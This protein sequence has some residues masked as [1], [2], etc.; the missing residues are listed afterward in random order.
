MNGNIKTGISEID[1]FQVQLIKGELILITGIDEISNSSFAYRLHKSIRNENHVMYF[2]LEKPYIEAITIE[3]SVEEIEAAFD[4]NY[5]W[6]THIIDACAYHKTKFGELNVVIIDSLK[7]INYCGF[8]DENCYKEYTE[9]ANSLSNMARE[10][11]CAVVLISEL[12]VD[13]KER[14]PKLIYVREQLGAF[15]QYADKILMLFREKGDSRIHINIAK[16]R[17]GPT[18]IVILENSNG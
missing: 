16:H 13:N 18:G 3:N 12:F 7:Y 6:L 2:D 5:I 15:E 10:L 8:D 14:M 11:D 17:G 1:D 9:I 4:T